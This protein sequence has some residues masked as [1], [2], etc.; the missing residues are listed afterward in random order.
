MDTS[1]FF[2]LGKRV[3]QLRKSITA[4]KCYWVVNFLCH[5]IG[6][7]TIFSQNYLFHDVKADGYWRCRIYWEAGGRGAEEGVLNA[8][9][10]WVNLTLYPRSISTVSFHPA[11][12]HMLLKT[13]MWRKNLYIDLTFY[14][15][16]VSAWVSWGRLLRRRSFWG[17]NLMLGHK[18]LGQTWD[19]KLKYFKQILLF[20]LFNLFNFEFI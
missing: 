3:A 4:T 11:F 1:V 18:R 6:K 20:D 16:V 9:I 7:R 19:T 2:F 15:Q 8:E 14:F 12:I 13:R 10:W 5:G 17:L